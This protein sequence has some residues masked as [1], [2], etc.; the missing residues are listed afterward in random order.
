MSHSVVKRKILDKLDYVVINTDY[1]ERLDLDALIKYWDVEH[2]RADELEASGLEKY[3]TLVKRG[4]LFML[5]KEIGD[6]IRKVKWFVE[7]TPEFTEIYD[8]LDPDQEGL[9]C[10][11]DSVF[12]AFFLADIIKNREISHCCIFNVCKLEYLSVNSKKVLV[13][14]FDSESG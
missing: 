2:D 12:D 4:C 13:I 8:S 3:E 11:C 10:L 6:R 5:Y 14:E 9:V 1:I 7:K